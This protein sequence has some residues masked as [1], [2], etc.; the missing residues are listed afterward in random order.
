MR[1]LDVAWWNCKR[2]CKLVTEDGGE[3]GRGSVDTYYVNA[4]S[5]CRSVASESAVL[6]LIDEQADPSLLTPNDGNVW[7]SSGGTL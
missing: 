5:L 4:M 1:E 7:L 3:G 6:E 2:T